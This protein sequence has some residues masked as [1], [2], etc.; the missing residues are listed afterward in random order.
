MCFCAAKSYHQ[1]VGII[2]GRKLD[3]DGGK[4][5]ISELNYKQFSDDK[6]AG[7]FNYHDS[8]T[9]LKDCYVRDVFD[10]NHTIIEQNQHPRIFRIVYPYYSYV[11]AVYNNLQNTEAGIVIFYRVNHRILLD[12]NSS[13]N[14]KVNDKGFTCFYRGFYTS[15]ATERAILISQKNWKV[16]HAFKRGTGQAFIA[17]KLVVCQMF[18]DCY[19][20]TR[21]GP[22]FDVNCEWKNNF[23]ISSSTV[24]KGKCLNIVN[25]QPSLLYKGKA[26]NSLIKVTTLNVNLKNNYMIATLIVGTSKFKMFIESHNVVSFVPAN[27]LPSGKVQFEILIQLQRNTF[28]GPPENVSGQYRIIAPQIAQTE[29]NFALIGHPLQISLTFDHP[30]KTIYSQIAITIKQKESEVCDKFDQTGKKAECKFYSQIESVNSDLLIN[31]DNYRL[32]FKGNSPNSKIFQIKKA[33]KCLSFKPNIFIASWKPV[34]MAINGTNLLN[35]HN[36]LVKFSFHILNDDYPLNCQNITNNMMLCLMPD[37]SSISDAEY[38]AEVVLETHGFKLD[39]FCNE[40]LIFKSY[41]TPTFSD[42]EYNSTNNMITFKADKFIK[43]F[44]LN[45]TIKTV[46]GKVLSLCHFLAHFSRG[47]KHRCNLSKP[48]DLDER[49]K[50]FAQ[51]NEY[52]YEMGFVE[53]L[54]T[55]EARER[56]RKLIL[57]IV[58]F[59]IF[60]LLSLMTAAI[61]YHYS[62]GR[63]IKPGIARK[64]AALR[65]Q[66][67]KFAGPKLLVKPPQVE[68]IVDE[69]DANRK[70]ISSKETYQ[71]D[72]KVNKTQS[73][74]RQHSLDSGVAQSGTGRPPEFSSVGGRT[75]GAVSGFKSQSYVASAFLSTIPKTEIRAR[76]SKSS[77]IQLTK[78]KSPKSPKVL[79]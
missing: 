21:I 35:L 9:N 61:G 51:I 66:S 50:A 29:P 49:P 14:Y 53:P 58:L 4:M 69:I 43:L 64:I 68:P 10:L 27:N 71:F 45:F 11:V 28:R 25:L 7:S 40:S 26:G 75:S 15:Q 1:K 78:S 31:L 34:Q 76:K 65:K 57:L 30:V 2:L 62:R 23:C 72:S 63:S 39:N 52:V 18:N 17:N 56:T 67:K 47:N 16:Y 74:T 6:C 46:S 24:F 44:P 8:D 55:Y 13:C 37:L 3:S 48:I 79:R 38:D 5:R 70:T 59:I 22:L 32:T 41:P 42:A 33:P 60:V 12:T 36:Y 73:K 54:G 20:C 19:G 77:T